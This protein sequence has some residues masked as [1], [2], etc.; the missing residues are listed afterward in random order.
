MNNNIVAISAGSKQAIFVKIDKPIRSTNQGRPH[1]VPST[2]GTFN[3][4]S[5]I[6]YLE[7]STNELIRPATTPR[8]GA[9]SATISRAIDIH[10]IKF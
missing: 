5:V 6:R 1:V 8:H 9:K 7:L 4:G 2:A 10:L 3:F